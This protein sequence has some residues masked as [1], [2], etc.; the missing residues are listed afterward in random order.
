MC[1]R[2]TKRVTGK[3]GVSKRGGV[4][5]TEEGIDKQTY[6]IG[7]AS[8]TNDL[9]G[10]DLKWERFKTV[11]YKKCFNSSQQLK[12][13]FNAMISQRSEIKLEEQI[14]L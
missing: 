4:C 3:A 6:Y 14:S 8:T 5:L 12:T 11:K 2:E 13:R 10:Q 9:K 1:K 7:K